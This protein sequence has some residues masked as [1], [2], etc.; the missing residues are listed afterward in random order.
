MKKLF[1]VLRV[2][3]GIVLVLLLTV[4]A[5]ARIGG[6]ATTA[7]EWVSVKDAK[8]LSAAE[9]VTVV[10]P[11]ANANGYTSTRVVI[12]PT[13]EA[14]DVQRPC[15]DGQSLC[16]PITDRFQPFS[17]TRTKDWPRTGTDVESV[18]IDPRLR[19]YVEIRTPLGTIAHLQSLGEQTQTVRFYD[20]PNPGEFEGYLWIAPE[21]GQEGRFV[22]VH[23]E[24]TQ[25]LKSYELG[26]GG[27]IIEV[28]GP[29]VRVYLGAAPGWPALPAPSGIYTFAFTT[30]D[31]TGAITPHAGQ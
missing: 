25:M 23:D 16:P 29:T 2:P 6:T 27:I 4:P 1:S 19:V 18:T 11:F 30:H 15:P 10:L 22:T 7:P 17:A 31:A 9:S 14:I 13:G 20:L 3:G 12:N 24:A 8:Q 26:R 5:L 21:F 28:S